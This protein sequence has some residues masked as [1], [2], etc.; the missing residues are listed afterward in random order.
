MNRSLLRSVVLPFYSGFLL[1]FVAAALAD[2]VLHAL[3]LA[4]VGR[5]L[6]IAGAGLI[7]LS[8]GYSLRKRRLVRFGTPARLLAQHE[9]LT[10][11]G[12]L[13]VLVHAGIHLHAILPWLAVGAML[14]NVLSGLTGRML[15]DR[16]RRSVAARGEALRAAGRSPDE[17]ERE[18]FWDSIMLDVMKRWRAVHL[19]ITTAF[20]AL[21]L[22]HVVSILLLWTWR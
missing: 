7:L 10:W 21:A 13:M 14:V 12:T 18:L 19:P 22:A 8:F 3:G 9:S 11:A 20:V 16:S 17:V 2:L 1:L 15:L 4:S 6:G 5:W